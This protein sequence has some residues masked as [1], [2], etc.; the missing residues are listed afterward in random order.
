MNILLL[1]NSVIAISKRYIV[2]FNMPENLSVNSIKALNDS[3]TIRTKQLFS[4]E[5]TIH[6]KNM[7]GYTATL[8]EDTRKKLMA[9]PSVALV[10]EDAKIK[11]THW[12]SPSSN[13]AESSLLPI[14]PV[15]K[16]YDLIFSGHYPLKLSSW[17]NDARALAAD[18]IEDASTEKQ[19]K[20]YNFVLQKN[21]PWGISRIS[22]HE[23][24]YEYFE[25]AGAGVN[26]YVLDT[27]IDIKH[28]DFEGRAVWGFNAVENSPD[29]DEHGHGTHC[30][31][32]IGGK[33]AGIAK[34]AN[35]IAVKSL[36]A[37]GEGLISSLITG[38]EYVVTDHDRRINS[39]YDDAENAYFRDGKK[40]AQRYKTTPGIYGLWPALQSIF[41]LEN[42]KKPK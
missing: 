24:E 5:D 2:M 13:N 35:L 19:N 1:V 11:I 14:S 25:N 15:G 21:A 23:H 30:A 29:T 17:L 8:S 27:G 6:R 41:E 38:I 39:Y 32:T 9:D 7:T 26:V 18:D 4:K 22:G 3:N 20:G 12:N 36:N 16:I 42:K 34:Y 33:R 37:N 40:G 10:E 31:G 28:P